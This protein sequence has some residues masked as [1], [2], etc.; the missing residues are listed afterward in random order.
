MRGRIVRAHG[1][2]GS[3]SIGFIDPLLRILTVGTVREDAGVEGAITCVI[4]SS[5]HPLL[6]LLLRV[7]VVVSKV[8]TWHTPRVLSAVWARFVLVYSRITEAEQRSTEE[9]FVNA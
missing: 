6:H 1:H 3:D 7:F 9:A 8:D 2:P 5:T 4:Y